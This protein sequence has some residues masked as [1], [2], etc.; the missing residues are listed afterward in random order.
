[1]APTTPHIALPLMMVDGRFVATDQGSPRHCQDQA[2]FLCRTR[3]GTLE[4]DPEFGLRNLVA[5]LGPAAPAI[6]AALRDF[7][8]DVAYLVTEDV[9][10]VQSRVRNVSIDL[11]PGE[12]T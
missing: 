11:D 8:P 9:A 10:A 4:A 3:P 2:E 12:G 6:D 7:V 5:R 1:M